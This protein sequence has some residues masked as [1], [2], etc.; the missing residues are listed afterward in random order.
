MVFFNLAGF[1]VSARSG[2]EAGKTS[3]DMHSRL[4]NRVIV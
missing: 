2:E 4:S 1:H 3:G